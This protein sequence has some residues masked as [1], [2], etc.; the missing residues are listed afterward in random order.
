MNKFLK[1]TAQIALAATI[2]T[3]TTGCNDQD[4]AA[5]I[6]VGG[7]IG[8]I[9]AGGGIT[10]G[11]DPGYNFLSDCEGFNREWI[12]EYSGGNWHRTQR[13]FDPAPPPPYHP[14]YQGPGYPPPPGPGFPGHGPGPGGPGGFPGHGPGEHPHGLT[15]MA[16]VKLNANFEEDVVSSTDLKAQAIAQRWSL[17]AS[18]ASKLS[19]AIESA[20]GGDLKSFDN[21]G[22]DLSTLN[23]LLT[24]NKIDQDKLDDFSSELN[25]DD[26][27]AVQILSSITNE[28]AQEKK[29]VNGALWKQCQSTSHWK[30]PESSSCTSLDAKGCSPAQGASNCL[31]L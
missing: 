26:Q 10:V 25:T 30:T 3:A 19:K 13:R 16:Q 20:K 23:R 8:G 29:D 5:G 11:T 4:V 14:P 24:E 7:I 9:A 1:V 15:E 12:C 28:Y 27:T 17:D 21:I 6:I 22:L 31:A 2:V 18:S